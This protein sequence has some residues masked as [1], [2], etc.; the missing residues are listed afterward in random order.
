MIKNLYKSIA[1]FILHSHSVS[2]TTLETKT[3]ESVTLQLKWHHQFQFAGYYAAKAKGYYADAGLDVTIKEAIAKLDPVDEVLAG[4]ANFGVAT[5]SLLLAHQA[6]QPV[7]V[8]AV[9]F[10]HSPY[11]LLVK[12][13]TGI[14]S[15]HDLIGK[16]MMLETQADELLA[17]LKKEGVP[18]NSLT[19][20]HHDLTPEALIQSKANVMSAYATTVPYLLGS[21]N[22]PYHSFSP[23]SAGIDFYGDNLFT[24]QDEINKHPERVKKFRAA[25]LLGWKYAL[26]HQDEIIDLILDAYPNGRTRDELEYEAHKMM[27]LIHPELIEL[28]YM[29]PERWEHIADTYADLG[30]IPHDISLDSFLYEATTKP[31]LNR[32]YWGACIA[33][34]LFLLTLSITWRFIKLNRQLDKYLYIKNRHANI[35]EAINNISHQWKQP[36]NSLGLQFMRIEQI[37][38]K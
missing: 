9:I 15:I 21:F 5:S 37:I 19:I 13:G 20:L 30:L 27:S 17:Y 1:F 6:G 28:G 2:A 10:Q 29:L 7:V 26:A 24:T 12:Q 34:F 4:K 14:E 36:L 18:I 32:Y 11:I 8:L 3:L 33:F 16:R 35:G 23:R 25:S 22:I 38:I 31:N